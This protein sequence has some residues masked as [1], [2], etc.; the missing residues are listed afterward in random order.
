MPKQT[1]EQMTCFCTDISTIKESK[2]W[3]KPD[4]LPDKD[5]DVFLLIRAVGGY[6]ATPAYYN[7]KNNYFSMENCY[8]YNPGD[9]IAWM[10]IPDYKHLI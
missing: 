8:F 6:C 5:C 3:I 7:K 1:I 2:L 4:K 10:Y 9:I